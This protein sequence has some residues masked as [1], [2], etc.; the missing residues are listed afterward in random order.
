[1]NIILWND[2]PE[3]RY[4]SVRDLVS[5]VTLFTDQLFDSQERYTQEVAV[6]ISG[7]GKVA[8]K[9]RD[10]AN[11]IETTWLSEGSVVQMY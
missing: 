11:W 1:M 7:F 6:D 2:S 5:G 4:W 8:S 10:G 9:H 3:Q